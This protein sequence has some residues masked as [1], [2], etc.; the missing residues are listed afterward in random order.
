MLLLSIS[1]YTSLTGRCEWPSKNYFVSF[2]R[3]KVIRDVLN[4][5]FS[6]ELASA[7]FTAQRVISQLAINKSDILVIC[8]PIMGIQNFIQAKECISAI[9]FWA[10]FALL[11]I[12]AFLFPF[13][14]L[15]AIAILALFQ[16]LPIFFKFCS[17][18]VQMWL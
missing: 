15:A 8:L 11:A 6:F 9:A 18:V 16:F 17:H 13:S 5:F 12:F 14:Y 1:D 3:L 2:V 4:I 10:A 7:I